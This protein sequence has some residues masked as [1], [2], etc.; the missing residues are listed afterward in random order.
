MQEILVSLMRGYVCRK[1][2]DL[3]YVNSSHTLLLLLSLD[4]LCVTYIFLIIKLLFY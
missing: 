2:F 1:M 4:L 3:S